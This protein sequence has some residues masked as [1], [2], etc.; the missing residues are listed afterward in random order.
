M[1][2][3][4]SVIVITGD[5]KR[6]LYFVCEMEKHFRVL[7]VISE[8]K[9]D[10]KKAY[11]ESPDSELVNFH[12]TARDKS[13]DIY[14]GNSH[15]KSEILK[16]EKGMVNAPETVTMLA[17]LNAD[18][19]LLYGTSII[20]KP[21]LEYYSGKV[22]NMHLG[23]S[24]Y[25]R[26]S[27]TNFWP[28]VDG[29]PECVG[30]TIHLAIPQVDAGP[31][32]HQVRPEG[33]QETD[34]IHDLGNKVIKTAAK[35]M[36]EVLKAYMKGRLEPQ[37]QIGLKEHEFKR[38]DLNMESIKKT[39]YNL[40]HGMIREYLNNRLKR[41]ERYPIIELLTTEQNGQ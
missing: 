36:P 6:H 19:V 15:P 39:Y 20:K 4:V 23:L 24:P 28:I 16:L 29:L 18:L 5:S 35:V 1:S 3:E 30:A 38:L 31:I 9:F 33:I 2:S 25:Y 11:E 7:K 40:D 8:V 26:G 37:E 12:F 32:L 27:G 13:E 17:N 14:F 34:N 21:L 10:Y 22:I 41:N